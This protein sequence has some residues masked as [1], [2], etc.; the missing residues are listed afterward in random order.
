MTGD[1][2]LFTRDDE[3]HASWK[4]LTPILDHWEDKQL[5]G[6]TYYPAGTWGSQAAHELLA[7]DQRSWHLLT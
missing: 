5:Q 6:L 7:K 1:R 4:L 2:T 3:V